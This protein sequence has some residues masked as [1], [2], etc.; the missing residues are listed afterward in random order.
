M[1][2]FHPKKI[3]KQYGL[4]YLT[5]LAILFFLKLFYRE[6]DSTNLQWLLAPTTWW[7]QVLSGIPFENIP[8]IGFVNHDLKFIIAKSCSGF[9]FML[10]TAAALI[11]SFLHRIIPEA[12]HPLSENLPMNDTTCEAP[13]PC[14]LH[15]MLLGFGYI[16]AGFGVSYILTILVNGMRIILSIYI[17]LFLEQTAFSQKYN[18]YSGWLTPD[19]LHTLIG[20][21]TY[22]ASLLAIYLLADQ[23]TLKI[24]RPT[25]N[26]TP[27][28]CSAQRLLRPACWYFLFVLG[29]PFLNG[30]YINGGK[31][32]TD[33]ATL[34]LL[35]CTV[36]LMLFSLPF[37]SH[38]P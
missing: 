32:F 7:V 27:N 30:A 38:S 2:T 9:Q 22:F 18:V 8:P 15:R 17:P 25:N 35:T 11:F 19:R 5:T 16:I 10:I 28:G 1:N 29:I 34:I 12:G 3:M 20:T 21:V 26:N 36:V 14:R 37:T 13:H 6:A 24:S 23:M 31:Q 4:F 33:Y